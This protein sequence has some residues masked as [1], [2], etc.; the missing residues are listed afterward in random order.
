M[1]KKFHPKDKLLQELVSWFEQS[2]KDQ[3][4]E[5]FPEEDLEQL[6]EYYESLPDYE[7][8]FMAVN[9]AIELFPF[10][11]SFYVKKAQLYF[12][13]KDF[14]KA[15][16][17]IEQ[18]K[19]YESQSAEL[20][21]LQVDLLS[22]EGEFKTA[23]ERLRELMQVVSPEERI[24]VLLEIAD[25]YDMANKPKRLGKTLQEVLRH[26]PQNEEALH[27]YW[28]FVIDHET[29]EIGIEFFQELIDK[30]PYNFLAWYYLAKCYEEISLFEKAIESYE[31]SLAINEYY[32][33]YWDYC[34]CL[35]TM[36]EWDK[37]ISTYKEM[38][39][40]FDQDTSLYIEI[41]NCE[42]KKANYPE[43]IKYYLEAKQNASEINKQATCEYLIGSTYEDCGDLIAAI[44]H[45]QKAI[46]LRAGKTR[47]WNALARCYMKQNRFED[48]SN[49]LL[50]SLAKKDNQP[51]Q[52][53]KLATCYYELGAQDLLF[54]TL[55]R[56]HSLLPSH[57]KLSYQYA[58]YLLKN[59]F[60]QSGLMQLEHALALDSSKKKHIF[61]LF[62][63]LKNRQDVMQLCDQF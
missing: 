12:H 37:A 55:H 31:Y 46:E 7:K 60:V 21:L 58:G 17:T 15:W 18:A 22:A 30:T 32:F 2:V 33:A 44:N 50:Q 52:W 45:Y 25:V 5:F 6:I 28:N 42:K 40:Q 48:A 59:G 56:A 39:D 62:P 20:L 49:C 4:G 41:G 19:I 34:L 63:E 8:A 35:Q 51:K 11:G 57:V 43:A 16:E 10:S 14:D 53:M 23:I 61:A 26:R 47:Y 54:D 36:E 9:R 29:F 13:A 3:T 38:L 27:R 1:S 24:D